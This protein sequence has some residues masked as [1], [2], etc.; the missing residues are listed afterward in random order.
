MRGSIDRRANS[1]ANVFQNI[2]QFSKSC[3]TM[4]LYGCIRD[5]P[6]RAVANT[7]L[8]RQLQSTSY[9]SRMNIDIS[10][11]ILKCS[12]QN[13]LSFV[14]FCQIPCELLRSV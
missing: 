7:H 1:N 4:E 6:K 8:F 5:R 13:L 2:A 11:F 9:L 14:I 3:Y 12:S 10:G